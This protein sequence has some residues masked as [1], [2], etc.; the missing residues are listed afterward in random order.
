MK[1]ILLISA[2]VC[3][4][5]IFII[6]HT[7]VFSKDDEYRI[8]YKDIDIQV[9]IP[10]NAVVLKETDNYQS[11]DYLGSVDGEY[12]GIIQ[13]SSEDSQEFIYRAQQTGS[14]LTLPI[15]P[16]IE[17][18]YFLPENFPTTLGNGIYY[19]RDRYIENFAEDKDIPIN[20]RYSNNIT[21]AVFNTDT[22]ILYLFYY[23]S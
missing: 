12:F 7:T 13:I 11:V 19:F 17:S 16:E 9:D 18:I 4:L 21:F 2:A 3:I 10:K 20:D 8:L 6:I 15:T 23:D 22:N 1:K 5:C 14:W